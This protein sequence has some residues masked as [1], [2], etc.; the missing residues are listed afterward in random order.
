[1]ATPLLRSPVRWFG[2]K[3][4]LV[5]RFL[6]LI[7]EHHTYVEAFGGSASL[8][9]GKQPSKVEVYNDLDSGLVNFFRVLRDPDKFERF[10]RMACMTPYSREE[11]DACRQSWEACDD[12]VE[13]AYRW[14]VVARMSFSGAFEKG[15]WSSV[16]H[17]STRGISASVAVWLR[18]VEMLP[19]IHARLMMIQVE[20]GGWQRILDRYDDPQAFFYLDPPYVQN[21]RTRTR[22][23]VEM[24]DDEHRDLVDRLLGMK[25]KVLLS[26]YRNELYQPLEE[27]GWKRRDFDV[28]CHAAGRTRATGLLGKGSSLEQQMRTE[29]VWMNYEV[30][31]REIAE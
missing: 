21:T 2:S 16:T 15:G 23:T 5:G 9:F 3:S 19:E 1:M 17:E 27:V 30:G 31:G 28:V 11:F 20:H 12:D 26:G 22:Y 4:R 10:H 6:E 8:L 13:R 14:F 24:R 29:S 7:P 18:G 25:G